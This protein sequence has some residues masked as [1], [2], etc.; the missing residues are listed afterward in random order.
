MDRPAR[1]YGPEAWA[2]YERL[3]RSLDP[4]GPDSMLDV[5]SAYLSPDSAVLDVG[6]RDGAHLAELVRRTGARGVGIDPV[7]RFP[8]VPGVQFD[9]G[10]VEALPYA[11]GQFDLVWCRD[12]IENIEAIDDAFR[13]MARVLRPAG[14]VVVYSVVATDRLEPGDEALLARHLSVVRSSLDEDAVE[15]AFAGAGLDVER[16][17]VITTEW[18]E[19]EEERTQPA[20]RALL[21]LAR[22]RRQRGELV[23]E[24]GDELVAHAEAN[25]HWLPFL[26]LGKLRPTLWVL[27]AP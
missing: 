4:R 10:A 22:L 12:V 5:A 26:L 2:V 19:W 24:F 15:A 27:T 3:D 16:K 23:A 17:E 18:R 25:L 6:C 14:R 1:I 21:R 9:L 7:G 11:D 20:S 13:E 8:D